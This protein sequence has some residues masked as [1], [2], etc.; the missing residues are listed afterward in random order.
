MNHNRMLLNMQGNSTRQE[1]GA[2]YEHTKLQDPGSAVHPGPVSA[3]TPLSDE[4][5]AVLWRQNDLQVLSQRIYAL[6]KENCSLI[7]RINSL[8][9]QANSEIERLEARACLSGWEHVEPANC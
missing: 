4:L 5:A 1:G 2:E 8:M 9:V 6:V 7:L 3:P